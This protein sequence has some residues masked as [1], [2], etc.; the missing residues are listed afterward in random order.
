MKETK[1]KLEHIVELNH[2]HVKI[3]NPDVVLQKLNAIVNGG[4]DHLQVIADYD[5]T[6]TKHH[7]DG[8]PAMSSFGVFEKKCP[9]LPED[10]IKESAMLTAKYHPIELDPSLSIEEKIPFM[11]KWWAESKVLMQT[12]EFNSQDIKVAVNEAKV[13]FRDGCEEALLRLSDCNVPVLV[14]SAGFGNVV[15]ET[16]KH[17]KI[18]HPNMHVIS[19][20]IKFDGTKC[21]GFQGEMIHIYNKNQHAVLNTTY[22][23]ELIERENV[24]LLGD[25]LGDASMS[26]GIPHGT[27]LKVGFLNTKTERALPDYMESFDIVLIDDQTMDVFNAILRH[28]L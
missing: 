26:D 17:E 18:Y 11:E 2:D 23:E 9:N 3:K 21:L 27:V 20:F 13:P 14:F 8:V 5:R 6:L 12:I 22:F 19:N 7:V 25:S 1:I 15:L 28:V 24:I 16:L 10:Y 4:K